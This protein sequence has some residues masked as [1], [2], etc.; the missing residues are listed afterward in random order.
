MSPFCPWCTSGPQR[1]ER[2]A[3]HSGQAQ[4]PGAPLWLKATPCGPQYVACS[5]GNLKTH[6]VSLR[7]DS[8]KVMKIISLGCILD[9]IL[10]MLLLASNDELDCLNILYRSDNSKLSY[11]AF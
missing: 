3:G 8:R 9:S 6:V 4:E 2:R 5:E 11:L 7:E 1:G 10:F